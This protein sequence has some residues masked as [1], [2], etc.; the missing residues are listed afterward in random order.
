MKV[1]VT[2]FEPFGG[3]SV[4]P[5]WEAVKLL[6]DRIGRA[7]IIGLQLPVEYGRA[8]RVL[9][10]ACWKLQPDLMILTGVAGGRQAVTP[11]LV[12]VN[13]RMASAPDNAGRVY[14]GVRIDS[15]G[16]AARMTTLPVVKLVDLVKDQ[17]LPCELSLSAG[18]YVCN[19][20]YWYALARQEED[21][22]C[23]ALFVHVPSQ[24]YM[25]SYLVAD[26]LSIIIGGSLQE[27]VAKG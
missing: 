16:P 9:L 3:D 4:N 10:D 22:G 7:D 2:G 15:N 1:L 12:A 25:P 14:Q 20:L 13:W 17:E 18:S 26:A 21:E 6:P 8:A 23:P 24:E 11:E 5:S 19:D 27:A